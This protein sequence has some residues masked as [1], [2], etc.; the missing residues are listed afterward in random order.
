MSFEMVAGLGQLTLKQAPLPEKTETSV[1][2]NDPVKLANSL[3]LAT[4]VAETTAKLQLFE[5]EARSRIAK[6]ELP[7]G[8]K[9]TITPPKF[10]E[11]TKVKAPAPLVLTPSKLVAP[12]KVVVSTKIEKETPMLTFS[13]APPVS[14]SGVS[15]S[16]APAKTPPVTKAPPSALSALTSLASKIVAPVKAPT[17][18]TSPVIYP[19][20][21]STPDFSSFAKSAVEDAAQAQSAETDRLAVGITHLKQQQQQTSD[22][23]I[24]ADLEAQIAQLQAVLAAQ[25]PAPTPPAPPTFIAPE[26]E[27]GDFTFQPPGSRDPVHLYDTPS[28][29]PGAPSF[30]SRHGGKLLVGAGVLAVGGVA[31]WLLRGR[32]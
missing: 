18:T 29:E 12:T 26:T 22:P 14:T 23:D 3:V 7:V 9:L 1:L 8:M 2:A 31:F 5:Q 6:G 19:D 16:L 13:S 11:S 4:K 25:P 15:L 27:P 21:P 20:K 10:A 24:V 28:A 17:K 30:L 32:K